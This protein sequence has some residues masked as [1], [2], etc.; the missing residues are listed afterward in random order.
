MMRYDSLPELSG[1]DMVAVLEGSA[2]VLVHCGY[3]AAGKSTAAVQDAARLGAL[4]VDKDGANP[5]ESEMSALLAEGPDDRDSDRYVELVYPHTM[6]MVGSLVR[7]VSAAGVPVVVDAPLLSEA[8]A[9][10]VSGVP[11]SAVLGE[12]WGVGDSVSVVTVWHEVDPD[13]QFGRMMARGLRSDV[14]KLANWSGYQGVLDAQVVDRV[15]VRDVVDVVV[16][17]HEDQ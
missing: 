9:A 5:C 16:G 15:G 14:P 10:V 17:L 6:M 7:R 8:G 13:V 4:L 1:V 12:L 11:L 2:V 3:P